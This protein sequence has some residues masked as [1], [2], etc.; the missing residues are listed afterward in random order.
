SAMELAIVSTMTDSTHIP[1]GATVVRIKMHTTDG[2][3]VERELQMGR[4]TSEW[5]YD[6]AD[7]RSAITHKRAHIIESWEAEGFHGHHYLARSSFPRV[8]IERIEL[9]YVR[10][11]ASLRI[12]RA[13][14][15]DP[16]TGKSTSLKNRLL[17]SER[18][19]KLK[20]WG[21]VEIYENL[22]L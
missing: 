1:D 16:A 2:Y 6:R 9:E 19:R 13:A 5:A 8:E 21:D 4:D 12:V 22:K 20:R 14:L 17:P 7:V 15:Y 18:W 10:S 11:D 3:V